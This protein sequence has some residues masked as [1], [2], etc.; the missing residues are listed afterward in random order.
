MSSECSLYKLG[1]M[2]TKI[3]CKTFFA[4]LKGKKGKT[5]SETITLLLTAVQPDGS[6]L[7]NEALCEAL[8]LGVHM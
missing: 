4:S 3:K 2:N 8:F 6:N 7:F 5:M 1:K